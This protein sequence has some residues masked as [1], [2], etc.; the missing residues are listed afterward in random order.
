MEGGEGGLRHT[1]AQLDV[2][3]AGGERLGERVATTLEPVL[4]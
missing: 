2:V 4:R 3:R 1:R